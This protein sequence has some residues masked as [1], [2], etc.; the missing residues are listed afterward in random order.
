MAKHKRLILGGGGSQQLNICTALPQPPSLTV[1]RSC[2]EGTVEC[3]YGIM[4]LSNLLEV[5]ASGE[6]THH[7]SASSFCG[8]LPSPLVCCSFCFEGDTL[9]PETLTL[10]STGGCLWVLFT[11]Y[12]KNTTKT[13]YLLLGPKQRRCFRAQ[14]RLSLRGWEIPRPCSPPPP[15]HPRLTGLL[16][17]CVTS[18]TPVLARSTVMCEPERDDRK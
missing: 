7:Y 2:L 3:R 12:Y 13:L 10:L 15:A 18:P 11:H 8:S 17:C 16:K 9:T 1:G 14:T 4:C 6:M 5:S